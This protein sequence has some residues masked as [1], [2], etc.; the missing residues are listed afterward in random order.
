MFFTRG[1]VVAGSVTTVFAGV[2]GGLVTDA[3]AGDFAAG[4]VVCACAPAQQQITIGKRIADFMLPEMLNRM[5]GRFIIEGLKFIWFKKK[6]LWFK[7]YTDWECAISVMA[8][9]AGRRELRGI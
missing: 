3:V 5:F 2:T 8:F 4:F 9:V 6:F 1:T 7:N